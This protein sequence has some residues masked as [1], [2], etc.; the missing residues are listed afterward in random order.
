MNML[1]VDHNM[2]ELFVFLANSSN[3]VTWYP[4]FS[5]NMKQINFPVELIQYNM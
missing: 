2:D 3:I 5:N 4:L 1:L